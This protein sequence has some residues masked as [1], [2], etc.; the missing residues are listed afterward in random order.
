MAQVNGLALLAPSDGGLCVLWATA[1]PLGA[2]GVLPV[3]PEKP[4][5]ISPTV[6]GSGLALPQLHLHAC[7][8]SS[9]TPAD[10]GH[11]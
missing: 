3:L 1:G 10:A 9:I 2:A 4:S 6:Q 11:G 8:V 5:A 7:W